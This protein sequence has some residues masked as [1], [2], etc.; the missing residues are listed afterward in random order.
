MVREQEVP[1]PRCGK[2]VPTT[3]WSTLNVTVDPERKEKLFGGEINL[4]RCPYCGLES[5]MPVPLLYHDMAGAFLVQFYPPE[6]L[7]D[8]SFFDGF[9][10]DGRIAP[11]AGGAPEEGPWEQLVPML[12]ER[13]H[14]VFSMN[15]LLRYV[16]FRDRLSESKK[17]GGV[18]AGSPG[19]L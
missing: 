15:E 9:S 6:S 3:I 10:P 13:I 11:A 8:Q 1:C 2:I 12:A 14:V 16:T 18:P 7:E 4:F 19:M 5:H 17:R